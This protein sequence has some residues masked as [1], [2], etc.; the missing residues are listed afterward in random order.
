MTTRSLTR[1]FRGKRFGTPDPAARVVPTQR[2]CEGPSCQGTQIWHDVSRG[3]PQPKAA[4]Y[5]CF[6]RWPWFCRPGLTSPSQQGQFGQCGN[7]R[8]AGRA[9][10]HLREG[11]GA[12]YPAS[13][14]GAQPS[15]NR[16]FTRRPRR[17]DGPC[18]RPAGGIDSG[19]L[20]MPNPAKSVDC[21]A[22]SPRSSQNLR[23][24]C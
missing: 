11:D 24:M 4:P 3:R 9:A 18:T 10:R 1:V 23:R 20:L 2:V 16:G 22:E 12:G 19:W 17:R 14:S 21:S 15:V 13:T 7:H 8:S 5:H 6:C